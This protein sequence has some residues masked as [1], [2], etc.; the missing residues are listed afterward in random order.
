V[1]ASDG[2]SFRKGKTYAK[3]LDWGYVRLRLGAVRRLGIGGSNQDGLVEIPAVDKPLSTPDDL[4]DNA[5]LATAAP[6][7]ATDDAAMSSADNASLATAAPVV[8]TDDAA[9]SSADDRTEPA[10]DHATR[11]SWAGRPRR[12]G[13]AG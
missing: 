12:A 3:V 5:S 7:V 4:A 10:S 1:K 13:G 2:V 8:A 9:I 11:A 6:V